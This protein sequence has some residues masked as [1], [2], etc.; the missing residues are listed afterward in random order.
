M[1]DFQNISWD[2]I[3]FQSRIVAIHDITWTLV[4]K[5]SRQIDFEQMHVEKSDGKLYNVSFVAGEDV[6]REVYEMVVSKGEDMGVEP[7]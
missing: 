3:A 7:V 6:V 2:S 5:L 4:Q 1:K